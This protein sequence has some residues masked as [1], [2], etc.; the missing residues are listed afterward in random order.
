MCGAL[1]YELFGGA[2]PKADMFSFWRFEWGM[3]DSRC[4]PLTWHNFFGPDLLS[5]QIGHR[6]F[7]SLILRVQRPVGGVVG[8]IHALV[9]SKAA[10]SNTWFAEL[11]S[12]DMDTCC[13]SYCQ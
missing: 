8:V 13:S 3:G 9:L 5:Q 11:G 2:C 7:R 4:L 10:T 6:E 12:Q 1:H